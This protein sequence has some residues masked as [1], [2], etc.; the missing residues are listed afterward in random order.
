MS[1]TNISDF[2]IEVFL[3]VARS[4]SFTK[5]AKELLISQ[6]AVSRHITELESAYGVQLFVR[7]NNQVSLTNEGAI[8]MRYAEQIAKSYRELRGEM[9]AQSGRMCGA[10]TIG[11]STTIAQYIL[12][13]IISQFKERN[14]DI[15]LSLMT[16]NIEHIE[17]LIANNMVNLGVVEGVAQRKEFHYSPFLKDELVLIRA[18]NGSGVDEVKIEELKSIPLVV[19]E[20]GSGTLEVIREAL[21]SFGIPI[22]SLNIVM[23]LGS[24]E[25]IKRYILS[26]NCYAI[27]SVAAIAD[28]LKSG[29]LS[30]VDIK[31]IRIER[32]F[33]FVIKSGSQDR[34]S[35]MFVRFANGENHQ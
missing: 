6:P 15:E 2:R 3:S 35:E 8:F 24:S 12:P 30:I 11:A 26:G 28:E 32:D 20:R 34:L 14:P 16:G 27:I 7:M 19:R 10:L 17:G 13:S 21:K 29:R 25:A 33:S 31:G 9:A 22:S 4:L 1:T 5:A 18:T 23:Q